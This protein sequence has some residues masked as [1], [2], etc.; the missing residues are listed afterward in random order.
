MRGRGHLVPIEFDVL[1]HVEID[2]GVEPVAGRK[3]PHQSV[4]DLDVRAVCGP[5]RPGGRFQLL[6]EAAIGLE[7]DEPGDPRV[8]EIGRVGADPGAHFEHCPADIRLDHRRP[9]PLP[10]AGELEDVELGADVNVLSV[11]HSG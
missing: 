10:V 11:R 1:E 7:A 3:V 6:G 5:E 2:D 9:V 8:D 4:T